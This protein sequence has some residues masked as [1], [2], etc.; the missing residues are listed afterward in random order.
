MSF[1]HFSE[2]AQGVQEANMTRT[3]SNVPHV[4]NN[5]AVVPFGKVPFQMEYV[6]YVQFLKKFSRRI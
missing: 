2:E 4:G 3:F 6:M 1:F 5:F